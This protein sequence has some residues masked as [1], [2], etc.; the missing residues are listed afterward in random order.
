M[1]LQD[2]SD[3]DIQFNQEAKMKKINTLLSI[4]EKPSDSSNTWLPAL[5]LG[6]IEKPFLVNNEQICDAL[7]N[8]AMSLLMKCKPFFNIQ[9]VTSDHNF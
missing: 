8:A 9:S 3:L 5:N 7:I 2:Q 4:Q 1:L 6:G